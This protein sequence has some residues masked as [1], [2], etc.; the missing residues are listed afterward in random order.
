MQ[1]GR[2]ELAKTRSECGRVPATARDPIRLAGVLGLGAGGEEVRA[3][4]GLL[5]Q[6]PLPLPLPQPERAMVWG[7]SLLLRT[8]STYAG[9][10]PL[11]V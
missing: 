1:A 5:E 9:K 8:H 3:D 2:P 11:C 4:A 6:H 10:H 7:L